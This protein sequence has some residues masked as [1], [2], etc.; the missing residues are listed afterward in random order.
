MST[1]S[2]AASHHNLSTTLIAHCKAVHHNHAMSPITIQN[3]EYR[4]PVISQAHA[5]MIHHAT[6]RLL[7]TGMFTPANSLADQVR[8]Q[9]PG[10]RPINCAKHAMGRLGL[11]THGSPGTHTPG[12]T[13]NSV[14]ALGRRI[15]NHLG[16]GSLSNQNSLAADI[17]TNRIVPSYE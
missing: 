15:H 6:P 4:R 13:P 17:P 11:A 3:N 16:F 9:T 12:N 1:P 2:S 14:E 10:G 5:T 7:S 8:G